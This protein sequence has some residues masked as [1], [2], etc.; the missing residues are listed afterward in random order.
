M[1]PTS[2]PPRPR[3]LIVDD[4]RSQREHLRSLLE[5]R[6]FQVE[7]A[8]GGID[9]VRQIRQSPPD[10][11]LLDVVL[12]DLDGYSVCRWVRLTEATR[13]IVVIM[14]T[15]RGEVADRVAGLHVGADDYLSKPFAD[16]ELEARIR[17]GLRVRDA[18]A[19][20]RRKNVDLEQMLTRAER[21]ASTDELTGLQNRRRFIQLLGREWASSRRYGHVFSVGIADLDGFKALNDSEGHAVG[22][23]ALRRIGVLLSSSLRE[24]D[25]CARYGG[26][27]FAFL[28][29]HTPREGAAVA[30]SRVAD[31]LQ[32]ERNAWGRAMADLGM[33]IGVA[34]TED[35]ALGSPQDLVET[36]DRA[37]YEAKRSGG[38]RVVV[39]KDGM[40][41]SAWNDV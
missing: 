7:E 19:E 22:D 41:T 17:A 35:K 40:L 18:K 34:S 24:V 28:L 4:S 16:G 5:T 21:L 3:V 27:E 11:V 6:G 25:V 1:E 8:A 33:S 26:D 29:P 20:L 2:L 14:L 38:R 30:L 32:R 15:V 13:D 39:A 36:A 9:A 31:Q 23:E 10:V 12:D 37:L